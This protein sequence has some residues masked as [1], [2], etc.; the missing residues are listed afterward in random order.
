MVPASLVIRLDREQEIPFRTNGTTRMS[1]KD[2]A[3]VRRA[4][5]F[6]GRTQL[7]VDSGRWCERAANH[8][9]PLRKSHHPTDA[10]SLAVRDEISTVMRKA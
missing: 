7:A 6:S 3:E 8:A 9:I 2:L 4:E 10:A 1:I 5:I